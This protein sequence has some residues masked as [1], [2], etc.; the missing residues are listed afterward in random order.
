MRKLLILG[1]VL[2]GA[3]LVIAT[4]AAQ[5]PIR[6]DVIRLHIL[7]NSDSEKDQ[8]QKLWV[9]DLVLDRWGGKL[10]ALGD[11]Q[12][13]WKDLGKLAPDIE[14][15]IAQTLKANGIGYGV[16]V[17]TGVFDFPDR[18]YEGVKFPAGKYEALQIRLGEAKGRNWW[19]VMFPPLCLVGADENF[20]IEKYKQMVRDL[21]QGGEQPEAPVRSWLADKMGAG[22]QWDS[23]FADWVKEFWLSGD[24]K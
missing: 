3:M 15:D 5:K 2:M 4:C 23:S 9:R 22:K 8:S 11:A 19:C 7:A 17:R 6:T 14:K 13:A 18:E 24:G 20:D 12:T 21:K 16:D 10:S 1:I